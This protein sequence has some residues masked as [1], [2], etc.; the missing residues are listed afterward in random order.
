MSDLQNFV[1]L[2]TYSS[3]SLLEGAIKIPDL[4]SKVL[5]EKMPAVA[6]TD[7]GNLFAALE[8]SMLASSKGLQPIIGCDFNFDPQLGDNSASVSSKVVAVQDRILVIA[9]NRTGYKNLLK[10]SSEYYTQEES[11][12]TFEQLTKY[13]TGLIVL[14][15]GNSGTLAKLLLQNRAD[16]AETFLSKLNAVFKDHLYIE[17]MRLGLSDEQRV[18]K[19]LIELSIKHD[20]PLVATNDVYF[21]HKE[22]HEAHEV[23]LC[24]ADGKYLADEDRRVVTANSYLKSAQEMQELFADIPEAIA[25]TIVIAQRCSVKAEESNA[26]FPE[27]QVTVGSDEKEEL[28]FLATEGL[29]RRLDFL[30]LLEPKESEE[31]EIREKIYWDRFSYELGVIEQMGF[32]GYFLIVSDFIR[33]SKKQGIPVGPG[34]GSGAG[35][36]ISWSLDITDVD[37]IKFG[38]LFERFLNPE[39]ISL[40][41]LDIDFCQDRRDE[42][43]RYV[44]EKYG[45]ERVAHIITF[46]KLQA[47]AVVRDV[48]RVLMLPYGQVDMIAKMIP[49]NAVNPVTLEQAIEMEPGLNTARKDDPR[50]AKLLDISL[51][52]EGLHRHAS[53]HAAGIV[54]SREKLVDIVP[55]YRNSKTDMPVIQYSMKYAEA[56]GLIKFDF[57]GL[58][59]LTVIDK[60]QKLIQKTDADFDLSKITL[61]DKKTFA[62]LSKGKA[63]GVFQ[64]ES[65]G[66]KDYL[67]KMKPDSIEDIIALGA[68]YRPGPMDNIPRYINCKNGKETPQYMHSKLE[69]ILKRTFGVAIYQEQVLE[70]A[71]TLAGYTLGAADLLR[72]AMGKKIKSEMDAQREA[73]V[74]GA[75]E[76]GVPKEQAMEIF[77]SVAK[78]A[79]YGFPKAHAVAYGLISY[80]TAY[81]KAN[82]PVELLVSI[83]NTEI[84]DTDKISL[85]I[86]DAKSLGIR[87]ETPDINASEAYFSVDKKTGGIRYAL[88]AIKNVSLNTMKL[89]S[90]EREVHGEYKDIFDFIKRL[91][92]SALSK[93]QLEYLIKSGAFDSISSNRR[94]LFESIDTL[95]DCYNQ[96]VA[97]QNS[98]QINLFGGDESNNGTLLTLKKIDDWDVD[99]RLHHECSAI[100]FYLSGHPL[101]V[102]QE[103]FK[104]LSVLGAWQIRNELA[105]GRYSV[106]IAAIPVVIKT[107]SSPKGR[108]IIMSLSTPTGIL[109]VT[110]FDDK[111]LEKNRDIIYGKVPL[112]VQAE[113]RKDGEMERITVQSI[114]RLDSYLQGQ[115]QTICIDV[116]SVKAIEGL[117]SLLSIS[118]SESNV[119]I[120]IRI[121]VQ[122]NEVKMELPKKYSCNF[123]KISLEKLPEGV[124]AVKHVVD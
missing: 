121:K 11:I 1:H 36:V 57:L 45:R 65:V 48:G 31:K 55:L 41:D 13:A 113:V 97:E 93:R 27:Y 35:S 17:L 52:L 44:Q 76:N 84:D 6:I 122:D 20:I 81:L 30:N 66:M 42:V 58:K 77:E 124:T 123:S 40:P 62:M 53:T 68:L 59:T 4:V 24:I 118:E 33:W 105:V 87:V 114:S 29:Q 88:G 95:I 104:T 34:R 28:R 74:K 86:E 37:P 15:G 90:E 73:F 96:Y 83:L 120:I 25:N 71:R 98:K 107:K 79:G 99:E 19:Q 89:V 110:L 7:K 108:Y 64:F 32:A 46:G 21:L 39:R 5:E 69:E 117:K 38:L 106:K 2:R 3:Y 47:R 14:T 102:Y 49:F 103:Y 112:L 54:I 51:K 67:S 60:C 10:L 12:I 50:V 94:E 22:M 75:V 91:G 101:D 61:E 72:R 9:K 92:D 78:F 26:I 109:D 80:Q 56:A 111:I 23:L 43:I 63:S 115:K 100:G 8:F 119:S 82:Y 85:F 16:V 70:I 116:D 18:E